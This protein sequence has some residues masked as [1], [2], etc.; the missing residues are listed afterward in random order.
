[1]IKSYGTWYLHPNEY[2]QNGKREYDQWIISMFWYCNI[3]LQDVSV[4]GNGQSVRGISV[5]FLTMALNLQGSQQ[6]FQSFKN[7]EPVKSK[8]G[9][10]DK[11]R[12]CFL[13]PLFRFW[14]H[15]PGCTAEAD[16][17]TGGWRRVGGVWC[18]GQEGDLWQIRIGWCKLE[19]WEQVGRCDLGVE[20]E[21]SGWNYKEVVS[22]G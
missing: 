15:L 18:W 17:L 16:A 9:L 6:K 7:H 4:V 12:R 22:W 20:V 13:F 8:C 19:P 3:V 1:M 5:L 11:G 14:G 10:R 2:R 21:L